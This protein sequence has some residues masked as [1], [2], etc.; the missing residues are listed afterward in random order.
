MGCS[1]TA[2]NNGV[3]ALRDRGFSRGQGYRLRTGRGRPR[4]GRGQPE[5]GGDQVEREQDAAGSEQ[6]GDRFLPDG[7]CDGY[8][9]AGQR[10][11]SAVF[12]EPEIEVVGGSS[13]IGL[14][15]EADSCWRSCEKGLV[16]FAAPSL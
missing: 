3:D 4:T 12:V 6:C 10:S 7:G 14:G 5:D 2:A 13:V 1:R 16:A 8:S 15:F 11:G 9:D